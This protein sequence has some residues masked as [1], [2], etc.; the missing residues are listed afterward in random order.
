MTDTP[1]LYAKDLEP[2]DGFFVL[3]GGERCVAV[4]NHVRK[5]RALKL[6]MRKEVRIEFDLLQPSE[7]GQPHVRQYNQVTTIEVLAPIFL[8]HYARRNRNERLNQNQG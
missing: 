3:V 4:V 7:P 6:G 5:K 1:D 2:G 8:T